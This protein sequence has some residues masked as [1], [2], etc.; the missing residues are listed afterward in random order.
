MTKDLWSAKTLLI[1]LVFVVSLWLVILF[2]PSSNPRVVFFNV[3]QGDAMLIES[4]RNRVLVDGGPDDGILV[5]LGQN[6]PF[7]D[8]KI[9]AVIITHA[10]AD[11][12]TGIVS[13]LRRYH[14][15]Q[16]FFNQPDYD[17][18]VVNELMQTAAAQ[19]VTVAPILRGAVVQIASDT[20]MRVLWPDEFGLTGESNPNERS[21]V[22]LVKIVNVGVLLTGDYELR[23]LFRL[24]QVLSRQGGQL[25]EQV[26]IL[27]VPHQGSKEAV[28]ESVLNR[29]NLG[30][31]VISVGDNNFGHPADDT[32]GLLKQGCGQVM[33][34]DQVGDIMI[35]PIGSEY[36][37]VTKGV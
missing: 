31:C 13:V 22:L 21:V 7:W 19:G 28:S 8:R 12:L 35:E 3:G 37:V 20:N 6:I 15:K 36:R 10:H 14:V 16:M 18:P 17:S 27:K 26:S 32:M 24:D 33:R 25:L 11:H 23:D 30:L 29:L 4:G 9:D 5:H 2:W 1:F 34:T